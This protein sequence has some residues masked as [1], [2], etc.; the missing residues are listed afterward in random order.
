M[1]EVTFRNVSPYKQVCYI[2]TYFSDGTV[3]RGSGTVVGA[4]DVLTALHVVYSA[5]HGGWATKIVV[6]PAADVDEHTGAFSAELGTYGARRVIGYSGNWD[7]NGDGVPSPD[8]SGHDLALIGL[9]VNLGNITGSLGYSSS[10]SGFNGT[11]LGYPASGT[12]LMQETG[13]ATYY[14]SYPIFYVNDGLGAGASGGPLLDANGNIRGVLSAGD[15]NDTFSWYAALTGN[16]YTWLNQ[17]ISAND[18]LLADSQYKPTGP[19]VS[20]GTKLYD[21]FYEYQLG[22]DSSK[23]TQVYAYQGADALMMSGR[24]NDYFISKDSSDGSLRVYN[25]ST[26]NT[27]Y[28]HDVN[29]LVFNDKTLYVMTEDQAQIARL[30]TVFNRTPDFQGLAYWVNA[31]AHGTSFKTIAD[32][33]SQSQE[34]AQRYNAVDNAGFAGQ[35]YQTIL[36]RTGDSGGIAYW[37]SLLDNGLSRGDAM[38]S[39]TNADENHRR[40]EGNSGFIKIVDHT[41][42]TDADMVYQKGAAFGTSYSDTI[43]ESQLV[44]DSSKSSTVLG[45]AGIDT[46]YLSGSSQSYNRYTDQANI[47]H[48]DATN[49]SKSIALHDMN[50]LSFQDRNV[51]IL[52][53]AQAEVARLYTV[54]DRM[55][56]TGGLQYWIDKLAAGT[57][58]QTIANTFSQSTE[59]A[60]RYNAVDNTG[61]AQQLYS[62]ILHR[63]GDQGGIDYWKGQLDQGMS[64]GTAMIQFT[65]SAENHQ[66]TEGQNGFIQLVGSTDWV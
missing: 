59:F 25:F 48:L 17:Q 58:F 52:D 11:M 60:Q 33:F 66:L 62:T 38:I 7:T 41:A 47:V 35:L 3:F 39:F 53:N 44:L 36:G 63:N 22:F 54:F 29:A 50:V 20:S 21:I 56:E 13:T 46:I 40:T 28:L 5:D 51:F 65:N 30:F 24:Y 64:R 45:G 31:Y 19:G 9:D 8:E 42:W 61:F 14:P 18:D 16:N 1:N 6:T 49:G 15:Q 4:N 43:F 57:T 12:G 26:G 27:S 55:P 2:Q 32:S 23:T 10:Q 34:F 37:K